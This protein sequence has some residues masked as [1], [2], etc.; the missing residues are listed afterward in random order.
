MFVVIVL[1]TFCFT[2]F[3]VEMNELLLVTY[4]ARIEDTS[5]KHICNESL[6]NHFKKTQPIT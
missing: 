5:F 4:R 6:M 2:K 3:I 1:R